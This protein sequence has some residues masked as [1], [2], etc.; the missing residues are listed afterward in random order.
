M[1]RDLKP[2]N[3]LLT[4]KGHLKLI[5]FGS[6]KAFFLPP[7]ERKPGSKARATSFVGTAE[8]VSPEV[9]EGREGERRRKGAKRYR[10]GGRASA[11]CLGALMPSGSTLFR[12]P[13]SFPHCFAG[14]SEP[15]ALLPR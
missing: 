2:E 11:I 15:G 14:A 10:S 13:S 1:H 5:D 7:P 9:R 4:D 8:Y 3:L 12:S 6:A